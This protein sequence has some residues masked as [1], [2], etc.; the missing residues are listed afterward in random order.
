MKSI[1]KNKKNNVENKQ[2]KVVM[3]KLDHGL[4]KKFR[5]TDQDWEVSKVQCHG[6]CGVDFEKITCNSKKLVWVCEGNRNNC[7]CKVVYCN[8]CYMWKLYTNQ[9]RVWSARKSN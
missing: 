3:C 7:Y 8:K 1:G 2:P 4:A 5:I 6:G 9:K